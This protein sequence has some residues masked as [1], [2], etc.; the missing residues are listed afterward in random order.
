MSANQFIAAAAITGRVNEITGNLQSG[1]VAGAYS[2]WINAITGD[3][4]EIRNQNGQAVM[5]YSPEQVK[6]IQKWL[7]AQAKTAIIR[8]PG[9]GRPDVN[10][11]LGPVLGPWATR[12]GIPLAAGLFL[13]GMGAM[14]VI[15]QV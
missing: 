9:A 12:R 15:T 5:L 7:D 8:K 6:K 4:P 10:Y 3:T 2:A 13:L 1:A 11:N 14:W